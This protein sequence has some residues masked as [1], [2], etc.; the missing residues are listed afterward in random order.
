[1]VQKK[2]RDSNLKREK[3]KNEKKIKP[4]KKDLQ[5]LKKHLNPLEKIE[6][7]RKKNH[8]HLQI[9]KREEKLMVQK[10]FLIYKQSIKMN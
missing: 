8:R 2:F 6:R 1:M 10:H 5:Q 9:K 3:N 7:G 4:S